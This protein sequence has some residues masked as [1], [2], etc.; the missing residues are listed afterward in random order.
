MGSFNNCWF[1][2]IFFPSPLTEPWTMAYSKNSNK[3]FFFNKLTQESTYAMPPNAAAPFQYVPLDSDFCSGVCTDDEELPWIVVSVFSSS[4]C[5]SERLFWAW[6]DGVIVHDSQ[7]RMDSEKLSKNDVLSF[8]HQHHQHWERLQLFGAHSLMAHAELWTMMHP[9]NSWFV[10]ERTIRSLHLNVFLCYCWVEGQIINSFMSI[11]SWK[12]LWSWS[13]KKTVLAATVTEL[14]GS[15]PQPFTAF[16]SQLTGLIV[17]Q[18][19]LLLL[20]CCSRSS[21]FPSGPPSSYLC[22]STDPS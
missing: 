2:H 4:V 10:H 15:P 9:I 12:E 11:L 17:E 16:C 7:T 18:Q 21:L 5:H 3:K 8:I 1:S 19:M 6:V 20:A 13:K 14:T 22:V